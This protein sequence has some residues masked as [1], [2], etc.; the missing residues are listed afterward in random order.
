MLNKKKLVQKNAKDT[1]VYLQ[2]IWDLPCWRQQVVAQVF[3]VFQVVAKLVPAHRPS[4][5]ALGNG[6]ELR[7]E[8]VDEA[9]RHHLVPVRVE[10]GGIP[11]RVPAV[12]VLH[13][14][15]VMDSLAQAGAVPAQ[16]SVAGVGSAC[17]PVV[18]HSFK[19]DIHSIPVR[20]GASLRE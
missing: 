1:K 5:D 18:I 20:V 15:L 8:G 17:S 13:L 4:L 11:P 14:P 19:I 6:A 7:G 9:E 10:G 12:V 2:K 3:D 16:A